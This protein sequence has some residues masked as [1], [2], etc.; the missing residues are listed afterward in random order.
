MA[1][2]GV[3]GPAIKLIVL[4]VVIFFVLYFL[5]PE[6]AQRFF[7]T[8]VR[9]SAAAEKVDST[10]DELQD[11]DM[12]D[13]MDQVSAYISSVDPAVTVD[14][15]KQILSSPE[16]KELMEQVQETGNAIIPEVADRII[17]LIP[18]NNQ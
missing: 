5:V 12:N 6:S 18:E 13:I 7:G 1:H 10:V 9:D 11:A 16:A 8:S 3:I 15:L 2:R 17:S 4:A 14:Q